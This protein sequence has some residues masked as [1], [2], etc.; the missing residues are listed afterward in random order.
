MPPPSDSQTSYPR[1]GTAR[2]AISG[3]VFAL[4]G[5]GLTS[6]K[7]I[8][9]VPLFLAAWGQIVYGEWLTISAAVAYLPL[10]DLGM[11]NYIANLLTQ[12]HSRGRLDEYLKI[13][14]SGLRLYL[15]LTAATGAALAGLVFLL[16]IE[17]W[18][19][20]TRTD[21]VT[22]RL[23]ILLLGWVLLLGLNNGL[24]MALYQSQGEYPRK[25][26]LVN[27]RQLVML[28]LVA[29]ALVFRR[30]FVTVAGVY[31]LVA[32]GFITFCALDL[33][34]RRPR[35]EFGFREAD[36]KTT[37]GFF[38]P[39]SLFMLITLTNALKIHGSLL[40]INAVLGAAMVA[41][42]TV[43]RVLGNA[44]KNLVG[45]ISH[46]LWPELTAAEARRDSARMR[47]VFF[48][49]LKATLFIS[50]TLTVFLAFTGS[51]IIETWTRGRIVF[52]PLLWFLI[53]CYLPW[54][55]FW[56]ATGIFFLST[57]RH[58]R[59]AW[60]RFASAAT[61][62]PLA[63]VLTSTRAGIAGTMAAFIAAEILFCGITIPVRAMRLVGA[64]KRDLW[65]GTVG[66]GLAVAAFQAAAAAAAAR[67]GA[68]LPF[69]TGGTLI[70]AAAA[71]LGTPVAYRFWLTAEERSL[72]RRAW[73]QGTERLRGRRP[74]FTPPDDN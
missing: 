53:L 18:L 15:A 8:I 74:P 23:T 54:N 55:V 38:G 47:A 4:I 63:V 57:N 13:F 48:A 68:A 66:R 26:M 67:A 21:P 30:G 3:S 61:A 11:H 59:Y 9:L 39:G 25:T 19:N 72:T 16:P 51:R 62:I 49:L 7:Q 10:V 33:K 45:V 27:L 36:W 17:G 52:H 40:V 37:L 32:A 44:V 56:E 20:I 35:L 69:W 12:A 1:G 29:G 6:L 70:L 60:L 22:L 43:H 5:Q 34:R 58:R 24:V 31:L 42:F 14:H 65:L 64:G 50:F 2:R 28:L 71:G 46:S 73:R 41:V